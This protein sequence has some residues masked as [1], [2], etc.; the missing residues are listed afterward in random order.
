[1]TADSS[2]R[3]LV[4][5]TPVSY[6][7][8]M[9]KDRHTQQEQIRRWLAD[10][11]TRM[12]TV[13]GR[14]GIGKSALAAK[15]VETLAGADSDCRGVVNLSTRTGGPL[16]LERIFFAC[17]NLAAAAS[18]QVLDSIWASGRDPRDKVME[19]FT[20]MGDGTHVVVLDNLEDQ[21]SDDGRPKN[22]DL[23]LF[24]DMVFRVPRAPRLLVTTQVPIALDPAVRLFEARLYLADGLPV[25][26]SVELLRE[27]DRNG[28][29]GLIAAPRD[30]LERAARRLHGVPRALE[31]TV[32]A[33][34]EDHLTMPTLN[35]ILNDFTVAGDIVDQ[36]AQDR[37]LRLDGEARLTLDVLAVFGCPVSDEPVGWVL[38]PLAPGLDPA[39]AL[40]WLAQVHMV[41]R[42]SQSREFA[43]HPMDAD[44]AYAA[45]PKEGDLS[46]RV[47]ERRVAAWYQ[48]RRYP[49]PWQSVTDVANHRLE[50][51]HRLRA[52]DYD[53]C[54]LVLDEIGEFLIGRGSVREVVAM[55]LAIRDHLHD[56]DSLLAHLV[57]F[58][59]GR[60]I[61]GPVEEAI[62]PLRQAVTLA[63][64][65]GNKLQ[66]ARALL[67]LGDAFRALRQLAEAV[68]LL[69]R[70]VDV[71]KELGNSHYQALALVTLSL[72]HTYLGQ[73]SEALEAADQL[74]RLGTDGTDPSTLG[75]A[76]DARSAAYIV[77]ERWD[78]AFS[79]A[80]QAI[81][82]LTSVGVRDAL[83]YPGNVQGI[84]RLG[85]GR[86]EEAIE[87]LTRARA[88]GSAGGSPRA[89]GLCLYNLAW[90]QW[91]ARRYDAAADAARQAVEVFRRAGGTDV[92][93]SEELARAAAAMLGGD[94]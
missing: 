44:I 22:R 78:D 21:L 50:F 42:N 24:L 38:Q 7:L 72:S 39:R 92:A 58:G 67:W 5:G 51:D 49:P 3:C 56:N 59:L 27:L 75:Q 19:L 88:D 82:A 14:R 53:K 85:Q 2:P 74:E 84:A 76:G 79:A 52:G 45:L 71:A 73:V 23:D 15:V 28:E 10:P 34:V 87:L 63:E 36:L 35:D 46:R 77:A 12:V 33:M 17:A 91:M 57:G 9:F 1:M 60:L 93:A 29:A 11:A 20:A 69:Q 89:E 66:L 80:G 25:A 18:K 70:A 47:L 16:S 54:A 48:S 81:D 40:S 55:H 61:G 90:A 13:V 43:L 94:T 83:G 6:G 26:D 4:V 65:M 31:L 86:I 8:E 68:E 41:S 32:G 64:G 37:Y 30:E 62:Q